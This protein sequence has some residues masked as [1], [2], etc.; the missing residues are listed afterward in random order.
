MGNISVISENSMLDSYSMQ[1]TG[2]EK[3]RFVVI[4]IKD[5]KRYLDKNELLEVFTPG[6]N[7]E[8]GTGSN[9]SA[10]LIA[11]YWTIEKNGGRLVV[12]SDRQI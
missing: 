8:K 11:A 6:I 5:K 7:L 1:I 3:D 10:G 2:F 12:T 4:T 9:T